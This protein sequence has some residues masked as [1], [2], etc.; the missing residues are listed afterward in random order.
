MNRV[1]VIGLGKLGACSAASFSARGFEVVG[2]DLNKD[3]V[4]AIN[5]GRAPVVEPLLQE[6]ITASGRR[7]RATQDFKDALVSSDFTL[8]IVPTPSQPNG[9]FSNKYMESALVELAKAMKETQKKGHLFVMTSTVSPGTCEKV[10]I[11]L[12]ESVSGMKL[13]VDFGVCY[14]PEFIALGSV[15][16]DFLNPDMVLIGESEKKWGEMLQEAYER[17]CE[18]KPYFARMSLVSAEITKISLNSYVTMKITFANTLANICERIPGSNVDHITKALGAD[19][20]ISPYYLKG[21]ISFGGPCF[22]RDNRAFAAFAADY[23]LDAKQAK[24]TDQVNYDQVQH[25]VGKV[26]KV[27]QEKKAASVSILGLAYKPDTPVIEES[28]S[29]KIIHELLKQGGVRVVVYDPLAMEN[30]RA[31]IGDVVTYA[32]SIKDC[33]SQSP[34]VIIA[35]QTREFKEINQ[36]HITHVPTTVVD[37]WRLLDP[38]Q[39]GGKIEHI[40]IGVYHQ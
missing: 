26:M 16:K 7:L 14:N 38:T 39:F 35:T 28:P 1:S 4:D 34:I 5:A 12:I 21:G 27:V 18:N 37:C 29:V 17:A 8:L 15:V 22:P 13:N 3:F 30:V 23:G 10:F 24:T 6:K 36:S 32:T 11:P 25:L 20:R 19:K 2:V 40:P 9:H 31:E 33:M